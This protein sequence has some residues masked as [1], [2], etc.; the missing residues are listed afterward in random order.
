MMHGPK[1]R[2]YALNRTSQ[3]L[4]V[5]VSSYR[6]DSHSFKLRDLLSLSKFEQVLRYGNASDSVLEEYRNRVLPIS[7]AA[8]ESAKTTMGEDGSLNKLFGLDM[9]IARA[10]LSTG[11]HLPY[12]SALA[13]VPAASAFCITERHLYNEE[14]LHQ[15]DDIRELFPPSF[16]APPIVRKSRYDR[17]WVI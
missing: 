17:E 8:D 6:R 11:S 14:L 4:T 10:A 5:K 1:G 7:I 13:T 2:A 16:F 15:A 9:Y 3:R 12:T